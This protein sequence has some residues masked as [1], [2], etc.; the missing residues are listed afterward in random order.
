MLLPF[1]MSPSLC[2]TAERTLDHRFSLAGGDSIFGYPPSSG[3][4]AACLQ[5]VV[6]ERVLTEVGLTA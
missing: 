2:G 1:G 6:L 4:M 3:Q 5:N